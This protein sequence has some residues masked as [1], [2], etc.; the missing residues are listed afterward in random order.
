M[1]Y[2]KPTRSAMSAQP[3]PIPLIGSGLTT[4][5]V[6]LDPRDGGL[7]EMIYSTSRLGLAPK[8]IEC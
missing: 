3:A 1:T 8:L 7:Q 5:D 6:V 2:G 4:L